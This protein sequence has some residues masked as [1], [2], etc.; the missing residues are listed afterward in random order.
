MA[1]DLTGID[2]YGGASSVKDPWDLQE[3][4]VVGKRWRLK[5]EMDIGSNG[6][7]L[8]ARDIFHVTGHTIVKAGHDARSEGA[9]R[10]ELKVYQA[11]QAQVGDSSR[12][13][14]RDEMGRAGFPRLKGTLHVVGRFSIVLQDV[15]PTV[16]HMWDKGP[17]RLRNYHTIAQIAEQVTRA[18]STLHATGYAHHH[19]C[20]KN[21]AYCE[22]PAGPF[23]TPR[24]CLLDFAKAELIGPVR[25]GQQ[26][27][28]HGDGSAEGT[29]DKIHVPPSYHHRTMTD[30]APDTDCLF[31]SL[32]AHNRQVRGKKEDLESLMYV[33]AFLCNGELPWSRSCKERPHCKAWDSVGKMKHDYC[34]DLRLFKDLPTEFCDALSLVIRLEPGEQPDYNAIQSAFHTAQAGLKQPAKESLSHQSK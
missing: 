4:T 6:S 14:A 11:I 8:I 7:I 16:K 26:V 29:A 23:S 15:G 25:K 24:V 20:P 32:A 10:H 17:R 9:I 12:W 22:K 19:I 21:I 31:A 28:N 5:H 33:V 2:F 18:L 30:R 34:K 13:W 27:N 3:N 1:S